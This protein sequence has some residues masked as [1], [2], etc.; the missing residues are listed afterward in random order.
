MNLAFPTSP[1][2]T[3]QSVTEYYETVVATNLR[4]V[5]EKE[6][7]SRVRSGK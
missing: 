3:L 5:P 4:V 1:L 7:I 2:L 6:M